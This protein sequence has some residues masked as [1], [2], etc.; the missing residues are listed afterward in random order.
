MELNKDEKALLDHLPSDG[1]AVGNR[2]VQ[3]T[4]RWND[5]RYWAIRNSLVDKGLILRGRGR[6]GSVRRTEIEN[7]TDTVIIPV[8]V[9]ID[10][11]PD[12]AEK[13]ESTVRREIELYEPMAGVIRQDW[14]HDRRAS[15]LAVEVTAF[16][17]RRATGG[18]WSRPD[19][20]SI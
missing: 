9:G 15:P 11:I 8:S 18:T 20:V 3:R 19:I 6:G 17:G 7:A 14:A 12:A 5:S 13:I 10:S 2:T 16:Q 1:S 4:L